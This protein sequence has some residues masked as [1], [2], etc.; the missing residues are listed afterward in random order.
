LK[1]VFG[2]SPKYG[3]MQ[4]KLL[5]TTVDNVGRAVITP[6]PSLD[7]DSVGLPEDKAFEVYQR[8]LVRRL[9]RRGM[10]LGE[11]LRH[12]KDKSPLAR[13]MLLEEMESRPV[14]INRSP[15]LHRFGIMAFKPQLVKG[16]TLQVSPLIV[17]G[18]N[19]DFDGDAM[20]YHVPTDEDARKEALDRML[21]SRQLLSPADFK[22]PVHMPSQEYVGGL[23]RATAGESKSAVRTFRNKSDAIKAYRRGDIGIDDRVKIMEG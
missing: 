21:P 6:D 7:M 12:A 19:A 20:N 14:I 13:Q 17:R 5:S 10:S 11:A 1:G 15:V 8:F 23:Y 16:S 18:F 4:R 2:S 9:K 3:T 22:T